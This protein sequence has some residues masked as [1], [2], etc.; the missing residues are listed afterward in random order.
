MQ[1][2]ITRPRMTRFEKA[3][4]IGMRIE[5]LTRG[6]PPFVETKRGDTIEDIVMREFQQRKI[7]FKIG[8]P[9]PNGKEEFWDV[10]DLEIDSTFSRDVHIRDSGQ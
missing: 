6:A 2:R 8:R 3:S 4:I 10:N 5:Q 9:L 1:E 7:P